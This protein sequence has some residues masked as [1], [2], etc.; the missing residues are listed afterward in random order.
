MARGEPRRG[1][2]RCRGAALT[3]DFAGLFSPEA[4]VTWLE[5]RDMEAFSEHDKFVL[6]AD[7]DPVHSGAITAVRFLEK[8]EHFRAA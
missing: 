4:L 3:G 5:S 8:L 1:P 7:V 2:P 6:L